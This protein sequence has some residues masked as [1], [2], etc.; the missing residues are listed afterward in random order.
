MP[1]F[2]CYNRLWWRS[3]RLCAFA[4]RG[5][6]SVLPEYRVGSRLGF[7]EERFR[8]AFPSEREAGRKRGVSL[9]RRPRGGGGIGAR[10]GCGVSVDPLFAPQPRGTVLQGCHGAVP[11]LQRPAV[12]REE[13]P[14]P[15]PRLP[16]RGGPK[17]LLHLDGKTSPRAR[18]AG[19]TPGWGQRG[20]VCCHFG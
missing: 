5:D 12:R 9:R 14:P 3:P 10:G 7:A 15:F 19:K 13:R 1:R 18:Y 2:V 17:Q 16:D 6:V 8:A 11:Q 4:G 20:G